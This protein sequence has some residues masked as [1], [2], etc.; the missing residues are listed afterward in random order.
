MGTVH[1]RNALALDG[2][3][4]SSRSRR[5]GRSGRR[6]RRAS[7][8]CAR[9]TYEELFAA[10]D[11]DAV[12]VAA[13]SIDHAE[14]G[15]RGARGREAPVPREAGRDDASPGRT[16]CARP[17]RRAR[18]ASCRSA[19]TGASTRAGSRR[20]GA[21]D[22]G[23]DRPAAARR[24]RRARRAD[25][26]AG[27]SASRPAASCVDMASHDYD[28][29]CWFL[30]AGAGRGARG[31]AGVGLP[32]A[33]ARSATSTTPRSRCASTAAAS[34]RCTSRARA[35]GATTCAPR[36][37]ATRARSSSA[38][39]SRP[40]SRST[41]RADADGFPQDYRELFADA[42][43]A[44]LARVRRRV[45]RARRRPGPGLEDDR[46]AVAVGVA[47]RASAVAGRPLAVGPDWPWP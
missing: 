27:G 47:A 9:A 38:T 13:R 36:S 2:R 42:Y 5:P 26:R 33:R 40:A 30:G 7:S 25:A 31:A 41:T 37:S 46:R 21:V 16:R 18:S 1:A 24:R 20:D 28:A 45:P 39:P 44:E 29:A 43:V 23:D 14:H 22:A 12:V 6:R 32:G 8:A 10:D 19:T 34:R 3:A 15:V 4:S 35:R 11:V 17:P